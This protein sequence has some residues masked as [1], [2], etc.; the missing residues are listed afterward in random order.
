MTKAERLE[1]LAKHGYNPIHLFKNWY[2][3][4]LYP[5]KKWYHLI[6]KIS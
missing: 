6:Q 2:W 1:R 4:R 5:N 3:V